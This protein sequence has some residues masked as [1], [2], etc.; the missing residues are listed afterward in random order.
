MFENHHLGTIG[1][2]LF[3]VRLND[4]GEVE[5]P[6]MPAGTRLLAIDYK[7]RGSGS[8]GFVPCVIEEDRV[9]AVRGDIKRFFESKKDSLYQNVVASDH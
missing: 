4:E 7:H 5:I 1:E 9:A 6:V 8:V 2:F 3:S